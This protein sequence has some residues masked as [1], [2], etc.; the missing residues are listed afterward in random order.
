MLSGG[1]MPRRPYLVVGPSGTG[2]TTLALQFLC[3]GIRHGEKVLYV[4]VEDPPNE[5]RFNHRALRPLLDRIDVFDAIPDVMRYEHTPFKD[6][7]AVREVVPFARVPEE[8]RQTPEFSS[9]EIT[10]AALEQML[11][12]EV[13]KHGYT[14]LVVD[15][16]TALQYFCMKGYDPMIGAQT[17]LRFLTDLRVTSLL[18]VE[19]PLEDVE[20]PE[21]ML[22]RGE[23]RLFRWELDG[24]TVRAVGVEKFRGSAHDVRLHPY[25]ISPR[26]LDVQLGP[27]ISRDTR[28]IVPPAIAVALGVVPTPPSASSAPVV[29][30]PL[31]EQIHDLVT[32][33]VDVAPLRTEVVA[34]LTAA[35]SLRPEELA[36]RLARLSAMVIALTPPGPPTGPSDLP[37]AGPAARALQRARSRADRTREG[38]PPTEAPAPTVVG[39]EL[40]GILATLPAFAAA[41]EPSIRT[42][43]EEPTVPETPVETHAAPTPP[44]PD[45]GEGPSAPVV[46]P[47]LP[48]PAP[49]ERHRPAILPP[50]P[51]PPTWGPKPAAPALRRRSSRTSPVTSPVPPPLP[52]V[53]KLPG[54]PSL[55]IAAPAPAARP[56]AP[57]LPT[58]EAVR[59]AE[60]AATVPKTLAP[61]R[62][63]RTTTPKRVA[64]SPAEG[65]S[66]PTEEATAAGD[67]A[68][69]RRRTVRRKKAPTVVSATAVD[70]PSEGPPASS[71]PP[72]APAASSR[73]P[74]TP[75]GS[76]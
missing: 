42:A 28:Q 1:L 62:R 35:R 40:E 18:T 70:P 31:S 63:R 4:T 57:D 44:A 13:Q 69:P 2:K 11:R 20:S 64:V 6:I 23:V 34:A 61:R 9:V 7:A 75:A 30:E 25:R 43:G 71:A 53:P 58:P 33:G 10:G 55:E 52:V 66:L 59:G 50:P 45:A 60:P 15:S 19:A 76:A 26:G 24:A 51:P 14:R 68:K 72:P 39:R 12:S 16:L 47:A 73:E 29:A 17:F 22:A 41:P 32:L 74:T 36:V 67:E 56:A 46:V 54:A 5:V 49:S 37:S 27:T 3:E 8:I 21:R 48:G 38:I 65:S